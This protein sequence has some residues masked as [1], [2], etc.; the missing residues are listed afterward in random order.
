MFQ[1]QGLSKYEEIAKRRLK[2]EKRKLK[3]VLMEFNSDEI[4]G[5]QF[6]DLDSVLQ[7]L[8]QGGLLIL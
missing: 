6:E 1:P 5:H 3:N 8:S 2:K 4:S 7:V